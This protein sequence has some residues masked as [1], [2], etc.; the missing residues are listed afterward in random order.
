LRRPINRA[1]IVNVDRAT[2][3][4][5][6]NAGAPPPFLAGREEEIEDF[7]FLLGRL[8]NGYTEKSLVVTG[9]RGVGKTVL[10]LEYQNV[11]AEEDWVAV[12]AEVSKNTPFGPQIANL[13][14]RALLRVSPKAK[15]G[16]RARD[17]ASVLKSFSLTVQPDGSLTAGLDV[18]A[19][20]GAA[21]T[22]NLNED[23]ADVFEAVG[24]AASERGRGVV[25]LFD[26]IQFLSKEEL[27]AL[28]GAVHRTVQKKLPVTFAGAGLPQLPGLAGDAKSYAERLFRFPTIGELPDAHA[29]EALVEPAR[30]QDVELDEDAVQLILDY[31]EG[32]PYFIQEFGRAVWDI[33]PGP[34]IT[35]E[36]AR[37]AQD[38][39]EAEL[40]ESFFRTR[41]QRC[42]IEE[43]R[44]MRAMA[45][46][47]PA[48]QKASDV[49]DVLDR[50]SEQVAPLR[51]RLINKGLLYTPRYG[52]A[53]FTVPQFDRFMVRYM[54]L[55]DRK[56][57]EH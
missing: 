25:F 33:A 50:T 3:P 26:E 16:Q 41:I 10:L 2:N 55:D 54:D 47:G 44:Y 9:L 15:W 28:I 20:T 27:E 52:F 29:R 21:D 57:E 31:T 37:A 5:T 6:P 42:T 30:R 23:L 40:D 18:E 48:A 43:R 56:P 14:R 13:A 38:L 39:V 17:A 49:A 19:A 34:T 51:A 1:K 12:E 24:S 32:Y 11:A 35:A 8:A 53:K 45:Q 46:L 7:R 36:D 4:Y 22:G